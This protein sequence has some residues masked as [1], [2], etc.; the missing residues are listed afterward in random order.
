MKQPQQSSKQEGIL[1]VHIRSRS[2]PRAAYC[3]GQIV[4]RVPAYCVVPTFRGE[5]ARYKA[6]FFPSMLLRSSLLYLCCG[7][8][9]KIRCPTSK[10]AAELSFSL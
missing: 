4:G 2:E 3:P 5:E 9:P 1:A 10:F 6:D 7:F 8:C